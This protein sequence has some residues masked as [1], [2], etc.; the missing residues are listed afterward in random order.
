MFTLAC[1]SVL[2]SSLLGPD[3]L[4]PWCGRP[5]LRND[6]AQLL[7]APSLHYVPVEQA[8]YAKRP[9]ALRAAGRSIWRET[10]EVMIRGAREFG[11]S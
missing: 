7:L 8:M 4:G 3:L 9:C 1:E 10:V 2:P 11:L 5:S 6:D